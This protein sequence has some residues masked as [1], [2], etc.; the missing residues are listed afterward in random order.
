[1][2]GRKPSFRRGGSSAKPGDLP[3]GNE[4]FVHCRLRAMGKDNAA[5]RCRAAI[6]FAPPVMSTWASTEAAAR[7]SGAASKWSPPGV[8]IY[9][10][11]KDKS[12]INGCEAAAYA[13]KLPI[14]RNLA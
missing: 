5:S 10:T 14:L 12:G 8:I 1:M 9:L 4:P 6:R 3:A 7:A 13:K 11:H 2:G